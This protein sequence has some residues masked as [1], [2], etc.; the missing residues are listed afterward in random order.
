G[1][2]ETHNLIV[3]WTGKHDQT[4]RIEMSDLFGNARHLGK[5]ELVGDFEAQE[6][7]IEVQPFRYLHSVKTKMAQPPHLER[8]CQENP[9]NV[10]LLRCDCHSRVLLVFW[11]PSPIPISLRLR[12]QRGHSLTCPRSPRLRRRRAASLRAALPS[13]RGHS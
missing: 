9:T 7:V 12:R 1:T 6:P 11:D 4:K 3:I 5:V 2:R 8:A 10:V 13:G